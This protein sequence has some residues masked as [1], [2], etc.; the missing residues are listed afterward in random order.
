MGRAKRQEL[1]ILGVSG[2]GWIAGKT[3]FNVRGE[4][5]RGG[6]EK[7]ECEAGWEDKRC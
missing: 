4:I 7:G 1:G 5:F 6:E 3:S 2:D